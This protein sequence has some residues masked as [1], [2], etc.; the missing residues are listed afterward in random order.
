MRSTSRKASKRKADGFRFKPFSPRQKVVLSWWCKNSPFADWDGII[1]DGSIRSGKSM[2]LSLSFVMWAMET[3][4]DRNFG[5]CGKTIGSLRRN[6]IKDL[7]RMLLA[8]GYTVEDR[9]SLNMLTITY[10]GVS[11][12]FYLF[13]GTNESSQDLI[14]G[15]T[16]AGIFLD[17][18]AL[19]PESF[20]NQATGRCSV[21]G[22]K[23]WF[24]CNPAGSKMHWFKRNWID[25]YKEKRLVYLHFTMDDNW[26]LSEKTKQRYRNMYTG[27]FYRRYIEG[28]WVAAEGV[29]YDMWDAIANIYED[30]DLSVEVRNGDYRRYITIDYGTANPMVYL[31]VMDDGH[32]FWVSNE[33]YY[34]SRK[35]A[36]ATDAGTHGS[37]SKTDSEYADD[38]EQFVDFDHTVQIIIDPSALSFKAEL[39]NRGYH[40]IKDADNEV[41]SGIS[42]TSTLI[43]QRRIRVKKGEC[44]NFEKEISAYSWN[45]KAA[46]RGEEEPIKENDHAMDAMRYLVKTIIGK[47]TRRLSA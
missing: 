24:S 13:G 17:E 39:R 30:G 4:Q 3:F 18:A 43:K 41:K 1:C 10:K 19:M 31:D 29:I 40:R 16:L 23:L 42:M 25:R 37:T 32:I 2:T 11:N 47:N 5:I 7:K 45:E 44:P 8:R 20:V 36:K 22:A 12:D 35:F 6:V 28:L 46:A 33:Y 26:S 15:V 34:D 14:Q 27:A 38:F 9:L 21:E